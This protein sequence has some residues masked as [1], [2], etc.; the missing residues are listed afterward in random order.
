MVTVRRL[1]REH[2]QPALS[3]ANGSLPKGS[4][5]RLMRM[6]KEEAVDLPD[7]ERYTDAVRQIDHFLSDAYMHK[8]YLLNK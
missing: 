1:G 7:C 5:E 8:R 3:M 4:A 6:N 2:V